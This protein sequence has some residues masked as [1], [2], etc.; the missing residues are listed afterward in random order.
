MERRAA[1]ELWMIV[2]CAALTVGALT[3]IADRE[4]E[5]LIQQV[6]AFQA[7][8]IE[9]GAA[10]F[11]ENCRNCHGLQG[12]GVGELGPALNHADFFTTRMEEVHWPG[13]LQ[14]YI[15]QTISLGR[16]TATRPL[17][18]GDGAMAMTPWLQ[19]NGG[20][21]RPD[22]V[23]SL[24]A[25]VLNW[26]TSADGEFTYQP[27]AVPTPEAGEVTEQA[28]RGRE[29]FVQAGCGECHSIPGVS[30]GSTGPSLATVAAEAAGRLPGYSAEAYLRESVLIPNGYRPAEYESAPKCG[31]I[32]SQPQLD[33]MMVFL[34]S[35][36]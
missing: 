23:R 12:E 7:R 20:P 33:D 13:T 24:A 31:G 36:R 6:A 34:L 5:R 3:V 2:I 1:F 18:A 30:T 26:K 14:E 21:L 10:L 17:Y 35:L 29:V 22:E 16:L 4:P 8:Q 15:V 28:A 32:L 27:I 19:A 25:F 9:Q 11:Q